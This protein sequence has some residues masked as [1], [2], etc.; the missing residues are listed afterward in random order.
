MIKYIIILVILLLS[1][2]AYSQDG[3]KCGSEITHL[4]DTKYEVERKCGIP[5]YIEKTGYVSEFWIYDRG[6]TQFIRTIYFFRGQVRSI[7]KG[8]YGG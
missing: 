1:S 6:S 4:G 5:T 7:K 8:N 3:W 2:N